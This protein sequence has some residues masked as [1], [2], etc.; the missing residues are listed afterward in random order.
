MKLKLDENM[1]ASLAEHLRRLGHDVH[2]VPEEFLTGQ[3]DPQI[4]RVTQN[5]QRFLITQDLDFSDTRQF[6]PGTHAG[7]LLVRLRNPN[8][9]ALI[10]AVLRVF[11]SED[12]STWPGC[13]IVLTERK[14]RIH[15]RRRFL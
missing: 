3:S 2:T 8:R 9:L 11:L 5:E 7:I 13:T 14:L 1:P 12:L 4:W 6:S 15:R 10:Q